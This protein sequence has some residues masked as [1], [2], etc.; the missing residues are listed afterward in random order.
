[1]ACTS[2]PVTA[3]R[4][5]VHEMY[6]CGLFGPRLVAIIDS[7]MHSYPF[8]SSYKAVHGRGP[9]TDQ[10]HFICERPGRAGGGR[11]GA[12][13]LYRY[14]VECCLDV[15]HAAVLQ[16]GP[17]LHVICGHL[18]RHRSERV[19]THDKIAQALLGNGRLGDLWC[20]CIRGRGRCRCMI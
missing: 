10:G 11:M 7:L 19:P 3:C 20:W 5:M 4:F 1:M 17:V 18:S 6:A 14:C 13:E 8:G 12:G 9:G 15:P 16:G 2:N